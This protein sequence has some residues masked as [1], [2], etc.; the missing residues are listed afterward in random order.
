VTITDNGTTT[1]LGS[2]S[3]DASGNGNA[4]FTGVT[5]VAGDTINVGD[6]TGSFAQIRF[7]AS[8][9]GATGVSGNA[10]F[11]SVK[12]VLHVSIKGATA[13][14]TYNVTINGT[15]VGQITT[16]SHGYGRLNVT[17]TG[18][19]IASGSTISVADTTGDP[20]ILTGSF[21]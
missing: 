19:T 4:K 15:V 2:I 16:N 11:N 18:V 21:A 9:T 13:S 3:T 8:L 6:L 17:P 10:A 1:T 5:A 12:N 20:A 14:T 7:T